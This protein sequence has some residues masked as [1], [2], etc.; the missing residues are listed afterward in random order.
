MN[1]L[2]PTTKPYVDSNYLTLIKDID[3]IKHINWASLTREYLCNKL[4]A[5]KEGRENL[6]GNL[7]LL[8]VIYKYTV[9]ASNS[10]FINKMF[11]STLVLVLGARACSAG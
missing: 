2:C 8:Q 11:L 7:P 4:K 9:I 3:N 6:L 1:I 10:T 5:Y